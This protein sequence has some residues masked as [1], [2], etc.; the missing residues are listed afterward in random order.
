MVINLPISLIGIA[1]IIAQL[2]RVI[3]RVQLFLYFVEISHQVL[4]FYSQETDRLIEGLNI[5]Y[6]IFGEGS[7]ISTNQ[8]RESTVFS[9]LIG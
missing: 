8:K 7:Q 2:L 1:V 5:E 4:C 6:G 9:L 3:G